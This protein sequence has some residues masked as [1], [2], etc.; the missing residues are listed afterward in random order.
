MAYSLA[1]ARPDQIARSVTA[2]CAR[3][4][5]DALEDLNKAKFYK[6]YAAG[7]TIAMHGDA[8][9][10]VAL[11]VSGAATLECWTEDGH[12]QLVGVLPPSDVIGRPGRETLQKEVAAVSQVTFR[13]FQQ[14]T[15]RGVAD[16]GSR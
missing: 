7:Q 1:A 5:Y 4:D 9:D 13:L 6:T 15:L 8:L 2:P 16:P 11:V 3:C 10:L 12:T 14:Q